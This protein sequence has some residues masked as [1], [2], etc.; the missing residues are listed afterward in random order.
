M[1]NLNIQIH[2]TAF[3]T[4]T[5]RSLNEDLSKDVYAKLWDNSRTDVLVEKY[6]DQVCSEEVSAHC[7][8]N[9]FFLEEIEWLQPEVLINFGS[10]FS[11]YP[12]LLSD[13]IIHIEID[14]EEVVSYKEEKIKAFQ[15]EGKLPERNIHFI[16]VDFS[17]DYVDALLEKLTKIS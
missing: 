6:L 17:Q 15:K 16:G 12:F 7:L 3:V 9:R 13:D 10:G 11:M 14:K 8:R 4:S 5:F 1:S 2:E